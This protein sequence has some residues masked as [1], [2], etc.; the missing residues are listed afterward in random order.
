MSRR[1]SV[2]IEIIALILFCGA[3]FGVPVLAMQNRYDLSFE[4][5]NN[6]VDIIARNDGVNINSGKWIIQKSSLPF[7][8]DEYNNPVIYMKKGETVNFIIN[9]V[10]QVHG[11]AFGESEIGIQREIVPGKPEIIEFYAESTGEFMVYCYIYC[12]YSHNGM[13]M[14]IIVF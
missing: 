6:F 8:V 10:D 11:F 7:E 13:T 12:Q 5:S 3:V 1:K 4:E 14:K 2:L 9:A